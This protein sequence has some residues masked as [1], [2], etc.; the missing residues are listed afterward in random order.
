MGDALCW[1]F[2]VVY[3]AWVFVLPCIRA[4]RGEP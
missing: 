3:V 4:W 2:F 1:A